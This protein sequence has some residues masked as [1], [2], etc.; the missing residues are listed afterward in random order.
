VK[1]YPLTESDIETLGLTKG[2]ATF[3][4]SAG[5]LLFGFVLNQVR[6]VS[7]AALTTSLPSPIPASALG[8]AVVCFLVGVYLW[9]R[10]GSTIRR[11]KQ[12]VK[13]ES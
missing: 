6:D 12:E 1:E 7:W 2:G 3:F 10:N 8:A 9:S 5:S 11:I 4:F 13:F